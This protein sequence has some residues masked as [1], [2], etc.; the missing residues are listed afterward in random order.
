MHLRGP[1]GCRER[2]DRPVR[3]TV[4]DE[5]GRLLEERQVVLAGAL[6]IDALE[7][8]RVGR[9]GDRDAS[10]LV[11]PER[12]HPLAPPVGDEIERL[13]ASRLDADALEVAVEDERVD[14]ARAAL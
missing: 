11:L 2:Q 10:S 12:E 5:R 6:R 14:E 8:A 3:R 1:A 13:L 7:H 9:R 4:L